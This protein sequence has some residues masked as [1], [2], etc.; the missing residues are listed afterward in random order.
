MDTDAPV[1]VSNPTEA[2]APV[3]SA[4]PPPIVLTSA[5]NLIQL[6]KQLKGVAK[7][8]NGTKVVTMDMVD[9]QAVRN[10]LD[11]HSLSYF[12]FF[13]KTDKPIKAVILHLP[14]NIPAEDIAQGLVDIGFDVI[15]VRQMSTTR[16]SPDGS[17]SITLPLFLMTLPKNTESPELFKLSS[18]CHI[19]IKVEAYKSRNTLTQ[20]YNCQKFG[21]V[22]ANC[23]QPPLY[24]GVGAG[25]PTGHRL[26]GDEEHIFDS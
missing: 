22:W 21:H 4:R 2:A 18:L 6:Q 15:S 19:S 8:C 12:T 26:P 17:A 20:C 10:F 16:R 3:K 9:Y 7:T 23:K 11:S 1:T 14:I 25:R 24:I 5:G 13:P